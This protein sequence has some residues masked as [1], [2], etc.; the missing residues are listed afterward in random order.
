MSNPMLMA[1]DVANHYIAK[2]SSQFPHSKNIRKHLRTPL[3][4]ITR[5]ILLPRTDYDHHHL[6]SDVV[7]SFG[8]N[9]HVLSSC[10]AGNANWNQ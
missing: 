3:L 6:Q 2:L 7:G 9:S 4:A 5:R 10:D 1:E 8:G